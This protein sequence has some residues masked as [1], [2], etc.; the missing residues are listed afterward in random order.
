MSRKM[1]RDMPVLKYDA[2]IVGSIVPTKV[3]VSSEQTDFWFFVV[4]V[5]EPERQDWR[6]MMTIIKGEEVFVCKN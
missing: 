1:N 3:K 4:A 2:F 5:E 6:Q